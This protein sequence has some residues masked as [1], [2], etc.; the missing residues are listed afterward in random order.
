[1]HTIAYDATQANLSLSLFSYMF[2]NTDEE[3][4]THFAAL[5]DGAITA[6]APKI[7]ELAHII[8]MKMK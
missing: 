6:I 4:E 3:A 8:R 7:A 2:T 1:M 5:I